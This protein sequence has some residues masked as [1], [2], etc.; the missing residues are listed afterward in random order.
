MKIQFI[1]VFALLSF[2]TS[3]IYAQ[4]YRNNSDLSLEKIMK[5]EEWLG[6]LPDNPYWSAEGDKVYFTWNPEQ[7]LVTPDYVYIVETGEIQKLDARSKKSRLPSY[8][9]SYSDDREKV[10]Y[11]R[12]GNLYLF[13]SRK[14][15][16][17]LLLDL[18][19]NISD[20]YFSA[21]E[22]HIFFSSNSHFFK[23]T[24]SE[25]MLQAIVKIE[26]GSP[27]KEQKQYSNEQEEWLYNDQIS[28]FD[29]LKKDTAR[30]KLEKRIREELEASLPYK[31]YS[32]GD[33][34]FSISI[35]TTGNYVSFLKFKQNQ[36]A[37][38]AEMPRFLTKSGFTESE[39]VRSKVGY[40]YG[41]MELGLYST[42]K[43]SVYFADLTSLPGIYTYT[44]FNEKQYTE[45]REEPRT[46]YLSSPIWSEDRSKAIVNV[47]STDNKDRWICRIDFDSASLVSLDHQRDDAWI[48]GPGIGWSTSSGTLGWINDH[49]IYFQSEESGYSHL[50]SYDLNTDTRKQLT[51]GEFEIYDP[52]LSNDSEHFYFSSNE[53]HYGE[54]HFYRMDVE[55][56]E[57]Q[58]LTFMKGRNDVVLSP[59]EKM[60]LIR[61]SYANKPWELYIADLNLRKPEKE[62]PERITESYSDEFKAYDWR[63]PEFIRFKASDGEMV[64]ARLYRPEEDK[65]NGAA[66]IFVHGAG[67]LQNA[68]KWWS[69]YYREYMFHNFLVDN[70]YTVLDIDYRASAGYGRDWRTAIYRHMGGKD[71]SDNVDGADYLVVNENIDPE[72]IG[73]YGGSYGGFISIMAQFTAP[74]VFKAGAA[75]RPVTDWAHY[76]HGYTSNILNTPAEDSLAYYRSS[77]IYHAEG[78][79]DHLLMCHGMVDDNV[80]FQDVVR[81]SQ[82]LI[83]LQ[84]DDWE[85]AVY[86]VEPHSFT[87]W[88]SWL[89]EY[90]RIYELFEEVLLDLE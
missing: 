74:G 17:R 7:E 81:L 68:H 2:S 65:K 38:N 44:V 19:D 45:E 55:G 39:R 88:T 41:S 83:E 31:I 21:N 90:K 51:A 47:R 85:L 26:S 5:G 40:P 72:K 58:K 11:T 69:N 29:V 4:S 73:I 75:L 6:V 37:K 48:A 43:D 33:R 61:H 60:M 22:E 24:P 18:D 27:E 28:L 76:N 16:S 71:L 77:P 42:L 13:D 9:I 79:Q 57:R 63:V 20:P 82:K 70:G 32:G 10:L 87:E 35:N 15:N 80:H 52:V 50:Y 62:T 3:I 64:P 53:E 59:D 67:Y 54:R 12:D 14:G 78:L 25:A 30:E 84:K 34:I 36:V 56:G 1:I 86:P 89:D 23:Y 46:V 66:V 8:G 49:T